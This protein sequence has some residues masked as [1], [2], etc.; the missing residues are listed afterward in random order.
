M[1]KS[2]DSILVLT[3]KEMDCPASSNPI[4]LPH[5]ACPSRSGQHPEAEQV[6]ETHLSPLPARMPACVLL[7]TFIGPLCSCLCPCGQGEKGFKFFTTA[8]ARL[9]DQAA[10]RTDGKRLMSVSPAGEQAED[11]C[12]AL[13]SHV[14]PP[15]DE[16]LGCCCCGVRCVC[17]SGEEGRAV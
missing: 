16:C 7:I 14:T 15:G 13:W 3:S 4:S 10:V 5:R 9:I 17:E 11:G 6:I 12:Q 8:Q 1:N 2:T